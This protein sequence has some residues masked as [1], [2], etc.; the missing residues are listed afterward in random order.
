[1]VRIVNGALPDQTIMVIT[2]GPNR[3]GRNQD[4]QS[5][6]LRCLSE[7]TRAFPRTLYRAFPLIS[8][9]LPLE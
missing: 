6:R 8:I 2:S 4:D 1:M 3:A 9:C 5:F 7:F